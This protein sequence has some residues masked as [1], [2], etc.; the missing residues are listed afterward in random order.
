MECLLSIRRNTNPT[1]Y[2]IILVD[3]G[4]GQ[5]EK[6]ILSGI[7]NIKQVSHKERLGFT[8]SCNHGAE[9]ANGEYLLFLNNDAQVTDGWL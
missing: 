9:K 7:K 8:L 3:D 2:E 6:N 4:S 1:I 5:Y